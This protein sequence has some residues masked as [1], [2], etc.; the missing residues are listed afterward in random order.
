L[1]VVK[2]EKLDV[3]DLT[4]IKDE[5]SEEDKKPDIA[6]LPSAEIPT[7]KEK[8][9]LPSP[10]DIK[11]EEKIDNTPSSKSSSSKI[12]EKSRTSSVESNESQNLNPDDALNTFTDCHSDDATDL[13]AVYS[14]KTE[15]HT[16]ISIF[17]ATKIA[18]S[19]KT[20]Q[21]ASTIE[22]LSSSSTSSSKKILTGVTDNKDAKKSSSSSHRSSHTETKKSSSSSSHSKSSSHRDGKSSRSDSSK[23]KSSSSSSRDKS[24]STTSS[25]S[26]SKSNEKS[27]SSKNK[28]HKSSSSSRKSSSSISKSTS[29]SKRKSSSSSNSSKSKHSSSSSSSKGKDDKKP[30]HSSSSSATKPST[31]LS[32]SSKVLSDDDGVSYDLFPPSIRNNLSAVEEEEEVGNEDDFNDGE[33]SDS[34]MPD[35]SALDAITDEDWEKMINDGN[36]EDDEEDDE[37]T[38]NECLKMYQVV[39]YCYIELS[40]R[41]LSHLVNLVIN[42][43]L[44]YPLFFLRNFKSLLLLLHFYRVKNRNLPEIQRKM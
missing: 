41:I 43:V 40:P 16:E 22:Q 27:S 2:Q 28:D 34:S 24:S 36:C 4:V 1:S 25:S 37:A 9:K 19:I 11:S 38:E 13:A 32:S 14:T 15:T 26:S 5:S 17:D 7:I 29:S 20:V 6:K 18:S 8:T 30:H 33:L 42:Q 10:K 31:S 12:D 44:S 21:K 23:N 3:I 35:L 39:R